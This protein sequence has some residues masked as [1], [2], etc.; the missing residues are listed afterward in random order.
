MALFARHNAESILPN[1]LQRSANVVFATAMSYI[2]AGRVP[3]RALLVGV[4][5]PVLAQVSSIRY[6]ETRRQLVSTDS[7]AEHKFSVLAHF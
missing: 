5:C 6:D 2:P 3:L 4:V 1:N 7:G